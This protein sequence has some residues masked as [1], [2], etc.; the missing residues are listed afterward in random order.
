MPRTMLI[1]YTIVAP[2]SCLRK[3][4]NE[5]FSSTTTPTLTCR[6]GYMNFDFRFMR[7]GS[8]PD[9]S[10]LG[11]KSQLKKKKLH[12]LPLFRNHN[13]MDKI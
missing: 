7:H 8:Q 5:C 12:A 13:I 1:S 4:T 9:F 6:T 10:T 3:H 2:F 11:I